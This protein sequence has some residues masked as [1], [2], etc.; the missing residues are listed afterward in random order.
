ML[1]LF[2]F[3]F[4]KI[5]IFHHKDLKQILIFVKDLK[6]YYTLI[7][8]IIAANIICTI[9][10][11]LMAK[12]FSMSFLTTQK[13]HVSNS[14]QNRMIY[15]FF[16]NYKI[17]HTKSCAKRKKVEYQNW[18]SVSHKSAFLVKNYLN[19]NID[20]EKFTYDL[21]NNIIYTNFYN[22]FLK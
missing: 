22:I 3:L 18:T 19:K 11:G 10:A 4:E 17:M 20:L 13:S 1:I 15:F 2:Q 9:N 21:I 5:Q 7:H 8:Y 12:L 6:I 16:S 14:A